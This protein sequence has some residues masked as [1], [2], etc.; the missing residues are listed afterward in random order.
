MTRG[1]V[2]ADYHSDDGGIYSLKVDADY[3]AMPER[4]WTYPSPPGRPVYPRGWTPRTVVGL[5]ELG[6]PR[7]AIVSSVAAPLWVGSV[8]TFTINASDEL[9]HTCTVFKSLAERLTQRPR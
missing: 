7:H 1:Y 3:A 2:W 4:G 6:H 8:T 5:D 9:P